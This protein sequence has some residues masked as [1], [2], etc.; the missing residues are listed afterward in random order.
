MFGNGKSTLILKVWVVFMCIA[1]TTVGFS[2]ST[3]G[4][5][6][7]PTGKVTIIKDGRVV[8]EFSK[9]APLPEGSLLRCKDKCAV[10]LDDTY[11]VVAP[12]TEFSVTPRAG[13]TELY[14]KEGTVF[15]AMNES[16]S[17]LQINTPNGKVS[18]GDLIMTDSE[19]R[20]YVRVS[21]NET[22]IGVI[23]GGT[24]MMETA[25][26]EMAVT[27]GNA[28]TLAA[29]DLETSGAA[30]DGT[31][32]E[33]TGGLTRNQKIALGAGSVAVLAAGGF[34]LASGGGGGGSG[35]GGGGDDNDDGDDGSP[36]SP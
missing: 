14:A 6:I 3:N 19:V 26:G 11:M 18:T 5:R 17:P 34:A 23:G 27:P 15:Y 33:E 8:G 36:S 9:E 28:I 16:S 10:K 32:A 21:G 20:G 13:H 22:E 7:I 29:A 25:S 35:G 31:A 1:M 24:M 30:A 2:A 4:A 12:G